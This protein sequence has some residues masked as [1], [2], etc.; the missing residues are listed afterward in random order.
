MRDLRAVMLVE[1]GTDLLDLGVYGSLKGAVDGVSS[2][3]SA[4][5]PRFRD[6]SGKHR[7]NSPK[8]IIARPVRKHVGPFGRRGKE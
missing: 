7:R 1:D 6:L 4:R 2:G 8:S 5:S 3:G